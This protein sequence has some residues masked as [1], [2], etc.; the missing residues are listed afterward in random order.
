MGEAVK[1]QLAIM[2]RALLLVLIGFAYGSS[3][4]F[5]NG[6]Q[7]VIQDIHVVNPHAINLNGL[8]P[9]TELLDMSS[10][11]GS[12]CKGNYITVSLLDKPGQLRL[13]HVE[14][15]FAAVFRPG[16]SS[17]E[18]LQPIYL[19]QEL[20]AAETVKVAEGDILCLI[21]PQHQE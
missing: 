1:E 4:S 7:F 20:F 6:P 3:A 14:K 18:P 15:G 16:V 8:G 13:K 5:C 12:A 11:P 9:T 2:I 21:L 10:P 19:P 17:A